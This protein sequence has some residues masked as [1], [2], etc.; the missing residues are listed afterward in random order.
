[1]AHHAAHDPIAVLGPLSPDP[2]RRLLDPIWIRW[3]HEQLQKIYRMFRDGGEYSGT[4]AGPIHFY[5]GNASVRRDLISKVGGFDVRFKR[6]EDVDLAMRLERECGVTFWF[7]PQA[8]GIH[9]PHRTWAS[10]LKIPSDYGRIDAE[11]MADGM[12]SW[13][14]ISCH[15]MRWHWATR[16]FALCSYWVP[17]VQVLGNAVTRQL[18]ALLGRQNCDKAAMAA[19]SAVY[20]AA[21]Y[22]SMRR[23]LKKRGC[24]IHDSA[25]LTVGA[26]H[27]CG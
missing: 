17:S 6:Q 7:D 14:Y 3:E 26:G 27:N 4:H 21:Y 18:S 10:W 20:N 5:S 12:V 22:V 9:R 8:D 11:R 1:M 25:N 15:N 16:A 24:R 2:A 19:L 13:N 23:Q